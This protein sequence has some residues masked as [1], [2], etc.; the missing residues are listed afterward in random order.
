MRRSVCRRP[1][2]SQLVRVIGENPTAGYPTIQADIPSDPT[3]WT[4]LFKLSENEGV[5]C[6]AWRNG[7]GFAARCWRA[8]DSSDKN[9]FMELTQFP[10]GCKDGVCDGLDQT[11]V[12]L[13]NA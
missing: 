9:M 1:P 7:Y 2:P 5:D 10:S 11:V 12:D 8:G 13:C 3:V 6:S 4:K